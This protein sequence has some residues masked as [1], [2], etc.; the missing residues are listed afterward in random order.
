MN[1]FWESV[2]SPL[3]EAL[4]PGTVVEVGSDHGDNTGKLLGFCRERGARL[5][6][7]DPLPKYDVSALQAEYGETLVFHQALSLDALQEIGC[8]DVALIDGDH[9]WYTV[10]GELQLMERCCSDLSQ[11]Y[12]LVL[13]HDI[14]WPYGR[15]DLYYDPE[16]VPEAY[17]HPHGREGLRPGTSGVAGEQGLNA[18]LHNALREN[19]PRNGVLAAAEDFVAETALDVELLQLPGLHGLGVLVPRELRESNRELA[20]VLEE[21]RLPRTVRRHVQRV[22]EE[23]LATLVALHDQSL[24]RRDAR[25]RLRS[26][27]ETLREERRERREEIRELQ[28]EKEGLRA[29]REELQREK[30]ALEARSKELSREVSRLSGWIWRLDTDVSALLASRGWRLASGLSRLRSR[31]LLRPQD[32]KVEDS[33]NGVLERFRAWRQG[34]ET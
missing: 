20:G 17:R 11:P 5:H 22:E 14:G 27:Q 32:P 15:R 31:V 4:G 29:E 8:V 7:V 13:L 30:E 21:L 16:T 19:T 1:R 18:D 34:R 33:I 10:H 12:P 24:D 25:D 9:N 28:V 2:I 23:R 26:T 6:V 3:L